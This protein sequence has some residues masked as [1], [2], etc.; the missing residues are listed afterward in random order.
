MKSKILHTLMTVTLVSISLPGRSDPIPSSFAA[1]YGKERPRLKEGL[2]VEQAYTNRRWIGLRSKGLAEC[3]EVSGWKSETLEDKVLRKATESLRAARTSTG[4][5]PY[6]PYPLPEPVPDPA[7]DRKLLKNLDLDRYCIYTPLTTPAA[8]FDPPDGLAEAARDRLALATTSAGGDPTDDLSRRIW[9]TQARHFRN[10]TGQVTSDGSPVFSFTG[11]PSVRLTFIDSQP[12]GEWPPLRP[13]TNGLPE[14]SP[15]GFTLAHL[16]HDLACPA[17]GS[18]AA[19]IATRRALGH[20]D[21]NPRYP[22]PT[23]EPPAGQSGH[24]GLVGDLAT[25]IYAEVL[26]WRQFEPDKK[27]ILN[28]SLGWDGEAFGDL[29]KRKV[30]KLDLSVQAVYN[31]LRFARRSGALVI[32]SAGNRR[33]G[34]DTEW[35]LLPAAWELRRP[36]WFRWSF[37][38]KPVYAVSGAEWQGLPIANYREGAW[39]RRVAYA[40]HAVTS[41]EADG[42]PTAMFTGTSVSAAVTSS[43]AAVVWHLRPELRPAQVMRLLARSGDVLGSRAEF[44]GWKPLSALVKAPH[45]RRLSLCAA[46]AR[47][48]GP[49]GQR[50]PVPE[51][52]PWKAEAPDLQKPLEDFNGRWH[53][54]LQPTTPS[55]KLVDM[56]SQ[57]WVVPQPEATPCPGCTVV[58]TEPPANWTPAISTGTWT[59]YK[60]P[61]QIGEDWVKEAYE[62][63][64]DIIDGK[65]EILCGTA[66]YVLQLP[67]STFLTVPSPGTVTVPPPGPG[68]AEIMPFNI[69]HSLSY[70]SL[71]I[72]YQVTQAGGAPFSVDNT[73]TFKP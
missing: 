24:V 16:A 58:R 45:T 69:G 19:E 42:D 39:T 33:G 51:C 10:Q 1:G 38:R 30:S 2:K 57:R 25:A 9:P 61:V 53:P 13:G 64:L 15:H 72:V 44:H 43:I 60:L 4:G 70:C 17:P 23:E 62:D 11:T 65:L 12:D 27:L 55:A 32:A 31:A 3:P 21:F 7:V 37:F 41:A 40:D 47:A 54:A 71:K 49:D 14:G 66:M 18:C 36:N 59:G 35:P 20:R 28:L 26:Y 22:L 63:D 52:P 73:V 50:C 29:K 68:P 48:C 34:S 46:V 5:Y 8:A 56:A 6:Q 67:A